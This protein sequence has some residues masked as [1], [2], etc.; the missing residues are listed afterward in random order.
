MIRMG[1]RAYD[2]RS[3]E[4][5]PGSLAGSILS[6]GIDSRLGRYVRAQK[7]LAYS[8]YGIFDPNRQAGRFSAGT[9]TDI[10]TAADAVEAMFKVFADLAKE[11][12]T[13][14]ELNDARLRI[15]G[16]MVM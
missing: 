9:E 11:G 5:F 16:S 13:E 3:E 1:I 6:A 4:K 8:V 12:V 2:I 14:T 15:V 7:G 10:S